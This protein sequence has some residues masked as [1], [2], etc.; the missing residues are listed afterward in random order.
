MSWSFAYIA[1]YVRL[2]IPIVALVLVLV[3]AAGRSRVLAS[4][5]L[6]LIIVTQAV[7][8]AF[9]T[10]FRQLLSPGATAALAAQAIVQTIL[11]GAGMILLGM[12]I[13]AG[14]RAPNV[15]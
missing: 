4:I 11:L 13:A 7:S 12:A 6:S 14:R 3:L 1:P 2:A 9:Y 8:I 15:R 10:I 5:G